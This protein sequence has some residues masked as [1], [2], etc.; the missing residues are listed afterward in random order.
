MAK[1]FDLAAALAEMNPGAVSNLDTSAPRVTLLPLEDIVPNKANFYAVDRT[2]LGPLADSI[3]LDGLL[4]PLV[5]MAHPDQEGKY[6]LISGHRRRAAIELL[7]GDK[8]QPREDLRMVPCIV[9]T[10]ASPALAELQLILANSTARRL[11]D[12]EL[13]KQAAKMELL[14][15][16]LKEEGYEFPGRMRDHVAAACKVSAPKLARL[17]VI[18][19]KLISDYMCL[20]DQDK[21]P[22]QTAY[23][24][25]R[26]PAE[27][28]SRLSAVLPEP[29]SGG[30]AERLLD[31]YNEGWRWEPELTCP[32]GKACRRGDTFLRHDAEAPYGMCGGNTC[33]LEC[34]RAKADYS[35]CDRMCS[36]AKAARKDKRD[37]EKEA[38]A[39]RA[40]KRTAECQAETQTYA[41]RLLPV[42]EAAGLPE[43]ASIPWD[44]YRNYTVGVIR[45]YAAGQFV[46]GSVWY[47]PSLGPKSLSDPVKTATLLN[48][49]AD[50]L[51]GLTE[52]PTPKGAE[53]S[54]LEEAQA[55][56]DRKL[57]ETA[58]D[59]LTAEMRI[60]NARIEDLN[61]QLECRWISVE[62]RMPQSTDFCCALDGDGDVWYA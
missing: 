30:A 34:R 8:E 57:G 10:Y 49:S 36:K 6:L 61:R 23:A 5:V 56:A 9:R 18:R 58:Q 35:P 21:L 4:D 32:D 42:I 27:L 46:E 39:R 15:Y 59:R 16:Q 52:D 55:E 7:V 2:K 29:P 33:C 12:P 17:K 25:A 41:Q 13:S 24:L 28:Q 19:E 20:F 3:A 22:E 26:M 48:C 11:S 47:R 50:F 14:L 45:G 62:E 53:A 38:E 54:A 31:K 51:L 43:D 44:Y 60:A 40:A 37:A 1:K